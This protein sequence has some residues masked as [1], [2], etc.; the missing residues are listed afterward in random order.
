MLLWSERY[1]Y[2]VDPDLVGPNKGRLKRVAKEMATH[3]KEH[4]TNRIN[5]RRDRA[6]ERTRISMGM[7]VSDKMIWQERFERVRLNYPFED[8]AEEKAFIMECVDLDVKKIT[9]KLHRDDETPGQM[10]E[11]ILKIAV[12]QRSIIA[13]MIKLMAP[14]NQMG[15]DE[16]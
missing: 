6:K 1:P 9:G 13:N 14:S 8:L 11:R 16:C 3:N 5:K 2:K 12:G 15:E 4:I 10:A 7:S